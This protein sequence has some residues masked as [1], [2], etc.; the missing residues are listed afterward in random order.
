MLHIRRAKEQ[1]EF[2]WTINRQRHSYLFSLALF[3]MNNL[4]IVSWNVLADCYIHGQ[5]DLDEETMKTRSWDYRQLS[6]R[7]CIESFDADVLCLQEIDHYDDFYR[8]VL[9]ELGYKT[10][11]LKR[12]TKRDGCLT[13][14][15]ANRFQLVAHK[16]LNLDCLTFI[17]STDRRATKSKFFKNNVALFCC[18]FDMIT[19]RTFIAA[20]CHIHWNPMLED[21]KFAQVLYIV[22]Q[23]AV[24]RA[25][26]G[27]IPVVYAGDF[28][29]IPTNKIY[30]FI[31]SPSAEIRRE[32]TENYSILK[33]KGNV[34]Y[35]GP[36]TRFVCDASLNK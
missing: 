19:K 25:E 4:R 14:Y 33:P 9:K 36:H 13:C 22:E 7:E 24:F 28:N 1:Q 11:F 18:L 15:R 27:G 3:K 16:E 35:Y 30:T 10:K 17:D 5:S 26:H 2:C 31:S 32:L 20:N 12:P 21:V 6:I 29:S 23:L 8:P 34:T